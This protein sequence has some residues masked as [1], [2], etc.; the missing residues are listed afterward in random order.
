MRFS[1]GARAKKMVR[2][3]K[4]ASS[5]KRFLIRFEKYHFSYRTDIPLYL[6]YSHLL[7]LSLDIDNA[8]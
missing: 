2:D 4:T 8:V 3:A 5:E 1:K 7:P 6:Y